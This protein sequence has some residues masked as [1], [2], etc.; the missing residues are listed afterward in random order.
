MGAG[1]VKR[2]IFVVV[3]VNEPFD[4]IVVEADDKAKGQGWIET[5]K[6]LRTLRD[7][8]KTDTWPGLPAGIHSIGL[9][10]WYYKAQEVSE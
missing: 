8:L 6:N 3:E 5:R 4:C 2:F 9:P 1:A 10:Y 7:C